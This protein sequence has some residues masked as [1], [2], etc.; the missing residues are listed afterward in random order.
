[1]KRLFT[2]ILAM[3]LLFP[4]A[5]CAEVAQTA[6]LR[7]VDPAPGP[8][9]DATIPPGE[10]P[11]GTVPLAGSAGSATATP[12][13]TAAVP[14]TPEAFTP[15]P[16]TTTEPITEP[17]AEPT[18]EPTPEPTPDPTPE[19]N[20][21]PMDGKRAY[22]NA[23]TANLR[24]GPGTDYPILEELFELESLTVTGETGDWYRV[25]VGNETGF[26]LA[27][28]VEFGSPPS[29][30]PD[31]NVKS[32]DDEE[33]YVN[34]GSVN[35]REGPGMQYDIV[36][37]LRRY[38]EITVTGKSGE[39]YRV[40]Y[41]RKKGFITAEFVEFGSAPTPTPKVTPTQKPEETKAPEKSAEPTKRPASNAGGSGVDPYVYFS[42]SGK[43]TAAELLLIAQVV[44]EEAK[45]S[46]T[47][48]RAAVANTI[49]NRYISSQYPNSIEGVIFQKNQFTVADDEDEIRSVKPIDASIEAVEQI[50]VKGDTFLPEDV[51]FFRTASRGKSWGDK[52]EYYATYGG[53]C[54]FRSLY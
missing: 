21:E 54:F 27:E 38:E 5:G 25:E 22:L 39:W 15:A 37:E 14:E 44:Q 23:G 1:M 29:P 50:F 32:M 41:G 3:A 34:A 40:E 46:S 9:A 26:I 2:M 43:F 47:E 33:A 7:P 10:T 42:D 51:L 45:G 16:A 17:T 11:P 35:L 49:Y 31:F 20:V 6:N 36:M 52:R 53:N 8:V 24:Q 28:F 30:T 19:Y 4:A 48:A 12:P 18:M 13:G